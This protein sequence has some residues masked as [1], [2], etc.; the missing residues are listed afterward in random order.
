MNRSVRALPNA[1]APDR[2]CKGN[3]HDQHGIFGSGGTT[4][5]TTKA[6]GQTVHFN[7]LLQGVTLWPVCAKGDHSRHSASS[8]TNPVAVSG[9]SGRRQ[10]SA[11][12]DYFIRLCA[13]GTRPAAGNA[14]P[15]EVRSQDV[16]WR[17]L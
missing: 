13:M 2:N 17:L 16:R 10:K 15:G 6:T 3:E 1:C 8:Q 9:L 7:F 5:V 11:F 14:P 4:F 12:C